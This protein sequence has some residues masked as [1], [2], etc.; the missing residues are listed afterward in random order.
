MHNLNSDPLSYF[1]QEHCYLHLQWFA[2]VKGN[3]RGGFSYK[4]AIQWILIKKY[5]EGGA[6]GIEEQDLLSD[7]GGYIQFLKDGKQ[8]L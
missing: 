3:R 8:I 2:S 5:P 7:V 4:S 6:G 1:I